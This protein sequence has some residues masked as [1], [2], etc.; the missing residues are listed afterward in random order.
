MAKS[1]PFSAVLRICDVAI[2]RTALEAALQVKLDRFEVRDSGS[3]HYAQIA[4]PCGWSAIVDWLLTIGPQI[5]V[6]RKKGAIGP[7]IIDLAISFDADLAS[8]SIDLPSYA[9]EAIGRHGI[10]IEFSV[11]RTTE[12][13]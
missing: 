3:A 4:A 2:T 6:L 8:L 5:S 12:R 13:D 7:A 10:D 11:Y 9:A 1:Q